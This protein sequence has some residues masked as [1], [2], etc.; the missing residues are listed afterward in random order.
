MNIWLNTLRYPRRQGLG[1]PSAREPDDNYFVFFEPCEALR[2][3]LFCFP[4][5]TNLS[6]PILKMLSQ[7]KL[8]L[9]LGLQ[10]WHSSPNFALSEQFILWNLSGCFRL[11]LAAVFKVLMIEKRTQERQSSLCA[12]S[13]KF[14]SVWTW[15]FALWSSTSSKIKPRR[16]LGV[17]LALS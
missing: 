5:N 13:K 15:R 1:Q 16:P 10:E 12:V 8:L 9:R 17:S 4:L 3:I 2:H 7:I 6:F 14:E 11:S